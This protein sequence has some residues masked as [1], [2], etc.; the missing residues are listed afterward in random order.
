MPFQ[1]ILEKYRDVSFSKRDQGTRFERLMRAYLLTDPKYAAVLKSVCMWEDFFAKDKLGGI[2]TGIDLVAETRGGEYW[3][4]QC[5][6]YGE[7][8]YI[9]KSDVDTFLATSGKE[10]NS[11]NGEKTEFSQRI[12]ISTTDH[13]TA[14]AEK[15]L[16][17]QRIPVTRINT[18]DLQNAP[19]VWEKLETDVHGDAARTARHTPKP[20]QETAIHVTAEYFKHARRGKLI[21][22]CGTGKTFT[23]LKIAEREA[24]GL[25]LVLVPSI[26]LVGQI[27]REWTAHAEKPLNAICVCSDPKVTQSKRASDSDPDTFSVVDL[28]VPATTDPRRVKDLFMKFKDKNTTVV[29][30]T[31]QSIEVIEDAQK[32]GLPEFG[33]IVCDEAHRTTGV[34]LSGEDAAVFVRVHDD[35][36][37]KAKKR[38]YMTATPRLYTLESKAEAQKND[39]VLCSMDDP[40]IYGEEIYRIGF[41]EAVEKDLLSDYKVLIFTVSDKDV[42]AALQEAI[43]ADTQ[44]EL[45]AD[46]GAKIVGCINALSKQLRGDGSETLAQ[47]DPAPMKRAVAFCQSIKNSQKISALLNSLTE[48][49]IDALP[50]ERRRQIVR[51]ES[52]HIDG[53]MNAPR[54]EELL[55]WIKGTL[56]T[57]D[58]PANN[59]KILSNVRCLSEGVDVPA[60]DA[61]MFLSAR[62][63]QVDVVQS[64]GR[65]MRKSPG[66]KYGYIIIPVLIPSNVEPDKALDENERYKVIWSVLNALRAHDDRFHAIINK[67]EL[68][69]NRPENIIIGGAPPFDDNNGDRTAHATDD[70]IVEQ[71]ELNL[72]FQELQNVIFARLVQKVGDR[73]YWED[74]AKSVAQIAERQIATITKAISANN[75]TRTVFNTFLTEMQT[76]I[77]ANITPSRAIEMLAQHAITAPVFDALFEDY[78]FAKENA[79]SCA[80]SLMLEE[81]NKKGGL[82]E[83]TDELKNFYES[84]HRRAE[85]IDNAEGRQKVV[86]E[87]Y[88]TFFKTAFPK[89]TEMLGI[90]YT[91]VEVVDFIVHSVDDVLRT[92][93]GRRLTDENVNIFDPFTGTGTFITRL[94]QSWLIEVKDLPRKYKSEVFANEIVLLA[95]YIACVN[96]ENA[97]HDA[98]EA[99]EYTPFEGIALTDTFQAWEGGGVGQRLFDENT[100]RMKR[101]NL[102]PITVIFG[103]PPYSTA[104]TSSYP[105]LDKAIEDT[106]ATLSDAVNKNSVYD[107]Y[108]RAFRYSTDRLRN[109]D[110]IVCFVSNGGWLDGNSTVGFRKSIENEFAKI[111]VFNLRGNARTSGELRRK[112]GGNIFGSGTRTPIA[113]TL[114]VKRASHVGKAE[115]YYRDIGD[116]LSREEK[117]GIIKKQKTFL[118]PDMESIRI[119]PNE[120]GDWIIERKEAFQ[121]FIHLASEEKFDKKAESMFVVHSRGMATA[122]DHWLYNFSR[123][124]LTENVRGMVDFYNSQVGT[125]E[126]SYDTTKISWS[127]SLLEDRQ[128]SRRILFEDHKIGTALYRPFNKQHFYFGERVIDQRY[129]NDKFFPTPDTKNLLIAVSGVGVN[130]DFSCLISDRLTDLEYVGK[131]QCFPLYYY[132]KQPTTTPPNLLTVESTTAVRYTRK[133]AI[134]D[135]ILS[136]ARTRYATA[137]ITK[138]DI[139]YYVY[140]FLHCP[141]YRAAFADDL[142]KSLPRIPLAESAADF[143]SFSKAGRDLAELHINYESVK[144][145]P[146]VVVKG[147]PVDKPMTIPT[148]LP[149]PGSAEGV[150]LPISEPGVFFGDAPVR[151][152]RLRV[153]KMR[154][155][156]KDRKDTIVFNPYVMIE[157]IPAKAYQYVVNGK[158]AIEWVMERYRVKTDKDSGILNDPNLYAEEQCQPDYVLN[159][160]LSVIAVSVRTAEIVDGLPEGSE[161]NVQS[162]PDCGRFK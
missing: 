147:Y 33:L 54:R 32:L 96:I 45:P 136:T 132:E 131:S 129:Q 74:W 79:V 51:I 154:F 3:A 5:K 6:C 44:G 121:T 41:G 140:G 46:T 27:L 135:R 19:V 125:E 92:E 102:K 67:I 157:N 70:D 17:G 37:V 120:H 143:W 127:R 94:I 93:F 12:W 25:A 22:A 148:S 14:N 145:L 101:Q 151:S 40:E 15:S 87:L 119:Q 58:H 62:N 42:P 118:N 97:Y 77:D 108:I 112:E 43:A 162:H 47:S 128:R 159:L 78:A 80:M 123:V 1:E 10:F 13:W 89:M 53:T 103:N 114:L 85:G 63:S 68:N 160:L 115:I 161:I 49:Y 26:A 142:K 130:K 134:S 146:E 88:N 56:K 144:P 75:E 99:T 28:T 60:L 23:A 156:A 16:S 7:T 64:V 91:P 38:L 69:K 36:S 150:V 66:K 24:D 65:V 71:M 124:N 76:S 98:M 122:K 9:D 86:I 59:C 152:A 57:T 72:K 50:E 139:F 52:N 18:G 105:Q 21:M 110:G 81:L 90:V 55:N 35:N 126:V 82:N 158:S 61:V 34:T 141:V 111:Y 48:K 29:F 83:N 30:S 100:D 109:G 138:E 11:P 39:A 137:A 20:H 133:D 149:L 155:L 31:Y 8:A 2:D 73:R 95:Y 106:Y 4:V 104:K 107:S 117:L 116:Y 113:I 84:V 153:E